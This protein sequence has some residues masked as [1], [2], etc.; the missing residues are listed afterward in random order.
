[1]MLLIKADQHYPRR[2]LPPGPY[3][4]EEPRAATAA[5]EAAIRACPKN[6]FTSGYPRPSYA[7]R[8]DLGETID[9]PYL[10][11]REAV[12]VEL[13]RYEFDTATAAQALT[14]LQLIITHR[15]ASGVA[16]M[17]YKG[18]CFFPELPPQL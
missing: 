5:L 17:P 6:D 15:K 8:Y 4:L 14:Q 7:Q 2:P 11:Y 9:S 10:T 12:W 3:L 16:P 18:G 1:M 13:W